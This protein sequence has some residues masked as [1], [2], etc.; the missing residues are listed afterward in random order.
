[1]KKFSGKKKASIKAKNALKV[2]FNGYQEGG[3]Y[4]LQTQIMDS[5]RP[6]GRMVIAVNT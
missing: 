1:M 4:L 6:D 5:W 2:R 3:T